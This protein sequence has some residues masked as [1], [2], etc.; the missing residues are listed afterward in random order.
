LGDAGYTVESHTASDGYRWSYRRYVPDGPAKAE[1]VHL[2]GIQSHAGWYEHSC[3]K[4]REAG[5]AVSFLDRRGSGVNQQARGDAPSFRRLLDD[6]A[7]YVRPLPRPVFLVAVSWG[8]KLAAALQRRHPGLVD[9]LA[10]LCPGFFPQVRPPFGTRMAILFSRLVRPRRLFPIPLNDP[11]LFTATPRWLE[12]LRS[13]PLALH[14]AT[15]RLLIESVRLDGYLRFVPKHV[16]V[17][18]LLMLAGKDRIIKNADTRAY[19]ERF[20]SA[21][22][23]VIEYEGAHH[24]LEFE[25]DPEPI[26]RDLIG[27]LDGRNARVPS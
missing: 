12:F 7:E 21:D 15:A 27:W 16:R 4:L 8:G 20:A 19:I 6:I 3:T 22:R 11:E 9:A 1:I 2:H 25:P 5:Y 13:D 18:V 26:L 23:K 14:H 10:L 24:T 17:P